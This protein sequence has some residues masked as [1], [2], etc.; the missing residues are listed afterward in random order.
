MS[1][2]YFLLWQ[3]L[4]LLTLRNIR[5][6]KDIMQCNSLAIINTTGTFICLVFR[7]NNTIIVRNQVQSY[8]MILICHLLDFDASVH[9]RFKGPTY[10]LLFPLKI[11]TLCIKLGSSYGHFL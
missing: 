8:I 1:A 9:T 6:T 4:V 7:F 11:N 2:T 10:T 5:S 3:L